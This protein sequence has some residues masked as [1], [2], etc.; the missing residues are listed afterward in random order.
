MSRRPTGDLEIAYDL[1]FSIDT[2]KV[3]YET[4]PLALRIAYFVHGLN[5]KANMPRSC[6][7]GAK[8][9]TVI[10]AG[11]TGPGTSTSRVL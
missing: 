5:S 11:D 7:N 10:Y 6:G 3:S 9:L 4:V 8:E 1:M 2:T